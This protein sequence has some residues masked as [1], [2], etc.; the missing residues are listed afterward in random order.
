MQHS[1]AVHTLELTHV[2][3]T[4]LTVD[5]RILVNEKVNTLV[6]H[7]LCTIVVTFHCAL[8]EQARR[9][10]LAGKQS[11]EDLDSERWIKTGADDDEKIDGVELFFIYLFQQFTTP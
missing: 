10:F 11:W 4:T 5:V 3:P 2:L 9:T 8:H 1:H 7:F 6:T